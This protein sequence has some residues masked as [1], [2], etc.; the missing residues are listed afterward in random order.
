MTGST[1][2]AKLR[3]DFDATLA[4]SRVDGDDAR[5]LGV[6][7]M[8][9]RSTRNADLD[10][11]L[12][13]CALPVDA[14]DVASRTRAA[15]SRAAFDATFAMSRIDD[16]DARFLGVLLG[17]HALRM[18][19]STR[20]AE[21]DVSLPDRRARVLAN[22]DGYATARCTRAASS[23]AAFDATFAM[24]R[25]DGDDDARFLGVRLGAH[26][27][28]PRNAELD[29]RLDRCARA[30]VAH[31]ARDMASRTRALPTRA[32]CNATFAMSRVDADDARFLGVRLAAHANARPDRCAPVVA[33]DVRGSCAE[34]L[35]ADF[36]AT[37]AGA[38]RTT[39]KGTP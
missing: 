14:R 9:R 6:R 32:D 17:A 12:D 21:A 24:S 11:R 5:F 29:A 34:Q 25:V 31:D 8:R 7:R 13:R 3:A 16:D 27:H 22:C 37:F 33:H 20:S 10:A 28:A 23:R 1:R 18:R 39:T 26:A 38:L 30:V 15:S 19:C 4:M 35:R 2:T 36:D